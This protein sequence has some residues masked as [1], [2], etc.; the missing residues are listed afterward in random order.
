MDVFHFVMFVV[1]L[2]RG[3][4]NQHFD[5][6]HNCKGIAGFDRLTLCRQQV[7]TGSIIAC[8]PGNQENPMQCPL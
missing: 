1:M 4:T 8:L 7:D 2:P 6:N 3:Y 5:P